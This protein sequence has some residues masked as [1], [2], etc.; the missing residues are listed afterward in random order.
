VTGDLFKSQSPEQLAAFKADHL[1]N[2]EHFGAL[3]LIDALDDNGV[4]KPAGQKSQL[5]LKRYLAEA[6]N[7]GLRTFVYFN[8]HS[9]SLWPSNGSIW[10]GPGDLTSR[11]TALYNRSVTK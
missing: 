7:R 11:E 1:Y 3:G 4:F 5:Y 8:V 10:T 9:Y 2:A 6:R